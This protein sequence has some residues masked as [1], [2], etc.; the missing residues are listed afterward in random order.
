MSVDGHEI[1]LDIV[2]RGI[3]DFVVVR[4][5]PYLAVRGQRNVQV[6]LLLKTVHVGLCPLALALQILSA[7]QTCI[8]I[9]VD[10]CD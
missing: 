9:K 7:S 10:E 2:E 5:T 3:L 6:V 8:S 1:V 4:Q